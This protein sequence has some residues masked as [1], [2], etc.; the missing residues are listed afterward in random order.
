[1]SQVEPGWPIRHLSAAGAD[2]ALHWRRYGHSAC[3]DDD[4]DC[5][6]K[7]RP[8][9]F[10]RLLPRLVSVSPN[11][12]HPPIHEV[13]KLIPVVFFDQI[14]ESHDI[15]IA[16]RSRTVDFHAKHILKQEFS[17]HSCSLM[18]IQDPN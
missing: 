3:E 2:R 7:E 4:E 8:V 13:P 10:E 9:E 14:V 5:I 17:P 18:I 1:M 16:A 6:V 15:L 11:V 12:I